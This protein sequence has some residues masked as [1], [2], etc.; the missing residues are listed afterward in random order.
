VFHTLQPLQLE[1][2]PPARSGLAVEILPV[3]LPELL[4]RPQLVVAEGSA[5]GLSAAHRWGSPLDQDM[6][7]VLA[8]DLGLLLGSDAVVA[9]PYG[10]RV[11][12]VY[13]VELDVLSCTAQPGA[14]TLE[15]M[16]MVTRPGAP[17]AILLRRTVLREALPDPGPDTL[18]AAYSRILATLGREIAAE[19]IR[20]P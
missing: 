13:R 8:Q 3:R 17:Q 1:G 16:W 9:S 20:R 11:T 14:L 15:A 10:E 6:Q 4:Q 7:R 5:Q 19:L 2:A 12:A 18:A